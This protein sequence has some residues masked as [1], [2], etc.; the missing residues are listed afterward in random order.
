[1]L[2]SIILLHCGDATYDIIYN[3]MYVSVYYVVR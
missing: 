2:Y 1:M 3:M